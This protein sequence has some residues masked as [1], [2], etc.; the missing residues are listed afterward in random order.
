MVR[1]ALKGFRARKLRIALSLVAVA[2]GVALI[3]GTYVLTDTINH[4]FDK[5]F[6]QAN[7]RT[8]VSITPHQAIKADNGGEG[9]PTIPEAVLRRV[10]RVPGVEAAPSPR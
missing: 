3:A 9:A 7:R 2:L 1:V 6:Q 8:D 5:I 4:S 10:Q